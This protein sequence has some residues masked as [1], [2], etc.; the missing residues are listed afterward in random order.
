M[1]NIAVS[2]FIIG[3]FH[4]NRVVFAELPRDG[5]TKL[6]KERNII[7]DIFKDK[8]PKDIVKCRYQDAR[9]VDFGTNLT[10][11]QTIKKP[12]HCEWPI[13]EGAYYVLMLLGLDSP[14]H[15]YC[16]E[17]EYNHWLV[18]NIPGSN[19]EEGET[20]AEYQGGQ[21]A[22][23]P[24][25]HRVVFVVYKQPR[26]IEFN[27][28]HVEEKSAYWDRVLFTHEGFSREYKLG[29]PRASNFFTMKF[30]NEQ[31]Y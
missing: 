3:L 15:K 10:L 29:D 1:F 30:Q 6:Y 20:I 19:F 28:S 25:E 8:A 2:I 26:K 13:E 23:E 11:L 27:A 16:Y 12:D 18:G 4:L 22:Y 24:G 31:D 9:E 7:P 21:I 5:I 17:R 14:T